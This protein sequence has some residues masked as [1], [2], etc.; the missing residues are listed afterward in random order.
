MSLLACCLA[1]ATVSTNSHTWSLVDSGSIRVITNG[2]P[3]VGARVLQELVATRALLKHAASVESELPLDVFVLKDGQSLSAFAPSQLKRGDIRTFGFSHTG[4]HAAFIAIRADRPESEM[5]GTLRHEFVHAL[6]ASQLPDAPAWLD[7]GLAEFWGAVLV[8]GDRVVVGRPVA[9]HLEELRRGKWLPL[10]T[11]LNQRRGSLPGAHRV[12]LFYAQS[13]AMVHY[14]LLGQSA[15]GPAGFVPQAKPVISQLET[16]LRQYVADGGFRE[17]SRPWQTGASAR[18]T[19]ATISE[20]RAI[21]ERANMLVSGE[22]PRLALPV[23]RQALALDP[24][25][26]LAIDVIGSYYFLSNQA[27]Q[28]RDWL[29]R[30]L[31]M[32]PS[33]YRAAL[34]LSLLATSPADRERY[35][36]LAVRSKPDSSV[37]WQRL[38]VM[39][40]DDGRLETVRRW[41]Q[42]LSVQPLSSWFI[43]ASM[44]GL[45]GRQ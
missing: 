33:S 32:N 4:A 43:G 24:R 21:A 41:C 8:E 45:G 25:E 17:V 14:L 20:A 37:A 3:E 7:E 28:A 31:A 5:L 36:T 29:Q 19:T 30:S 42:A 35:L 10:Q 12:P 6:T 18:Y 38:G 34:Y 13:W 2:S 1:G 22:Q 11:M 23:A 15:D 9:R 39:F 40:E 27:E 44:C 26:S 16:T